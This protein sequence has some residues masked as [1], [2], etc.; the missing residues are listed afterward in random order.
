MTNHPSV[1]DLQS[2]LDGEGAYERRE[3]IDRHLGLCDGCGREVTDLRA[4]AV[5]TTSTL[6]LLDD[7]PAVDL[8]AARWNVRRARARSRTGSL[9]RAASIAAS[10]MVVGAAGWAA[11]APGSPLWSVWQRTPNPVSAPIVAAP[12][13]ASSTATVGVPVGA[14][15]VTVEFTGAP[16]GAQVLVSDAGPSERVTA[17]APR[18]S[19]FSTAQGRIVVDVASATGPLS[20]AIPTHAD[21]DVSVNGRIVLSRTGGSDAYPGPE[22]TPTPE[23]LSF[24]VITP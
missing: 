10:I 23:G 17:T 20:V 16:A 8:E 2:Y 3:A 19:G 7:A 6:A 18:S 1:G 15:R 12:P 22:P 11:A 21:A 4:A 13:S 24:P 14:E 9:R 5:L